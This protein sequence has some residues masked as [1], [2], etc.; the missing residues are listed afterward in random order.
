[1]DFDG[2][3]SP[4]VG[5]DYFPDDLLSWCDHEVF[6]DCGAFDG[7]RSA[8][9]VINRIGN[10]FSKII[11]LEPDPGNFAKLKAY[12]ESLPNEVAEKISVME[13]AVGSRREIVHFDATGTTSSTMGSG[14]VN[15]Q[16]VTL[17]EVLAEVTP[18]YIGWISKRGNRKLSLEPSNFSLD[19]DRCWQSASITHK[20]ICG[21]SHFG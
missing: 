16:C 1:M 20:T 18:T 2:L 15:V 8:P 10:H 5:D 12:Q 7:V 11:A 4:P 13:F 14:A 17:D 9:V 3:S 19:A 6:V 21:A